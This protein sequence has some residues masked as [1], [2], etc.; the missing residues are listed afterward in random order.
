MSAAAA[1]VSHRS[2]T[3]APDMTASAVPAPAAM[4]LRQHGPCCQHEGPNRRQKN[5]FAH[6]RCLRKPSL[7]RV[8]M[9]HHLIDL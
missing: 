9:T 4:A 7:G 6:D 2:V 5:L 8:L 1:G 3:A